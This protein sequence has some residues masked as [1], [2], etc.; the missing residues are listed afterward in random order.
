MTLQN[1]FAAALAS[2][3]VYVKCEHVARSNMSA[4]YSLFTIVDGRLERAWPSS[5]V[6][7]GFSFDEKLAKRLGFRLG[8]QNS[9][10]ERSW[11]HRGGCGYDRARDIVSDIAREFGCADFHK[12]GISVESI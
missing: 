5:P 1:W 7:G 4:S 6:D 12:A 11:Q 3:I 9:K 10:G 2:K 8:K